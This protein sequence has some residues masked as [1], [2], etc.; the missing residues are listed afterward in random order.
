MIEIK[1]RW[2]GETIC[3]DEEAET[4]RDAVVKAVVNRANLYGADLYGANLYGANLDGANLVRANLDGANL[5][6]ANLDGANLV[7]AN[8]DGAN[9]YGANLYGANLDGANLVRAN[10]V[11]ANLYGA[12]LPSPTT[13]LLATWGDLSQQ[14]C[15]DLMLFDATNHPDPSAFDRWADGSGGCPY[16]DVRVGRAANFTESKK[17]WGQGQPCRPYDL[18]VRV[19]AEKCPDWTEQQVAEFMKAFEKSNQ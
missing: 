7:R 15:A 12:N 8:L 16:S 1:H 2:T 5:Y 10:L 17:Y 9:L 11:R 6:G 18:M 4:L 14:L 19:L 13:V 3:C